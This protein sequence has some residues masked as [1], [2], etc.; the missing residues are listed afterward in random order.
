MKFRVTCAATPISYAQALDLLG[1]DASFR[2]FLTHLLASSEYGAF[3]WETPP[4]TRASASRPFEFV[5]VDDPYLNRSPDR[6]AFG[7]Y[8]ADAHE[9]VT[10]RAVPN[11]GGNATLIVPKEISHAEHYV[12][13]AAFL[14][15]APQS[16]VHAL[17]QCL[18]STGRSALAN[19]PTW[20]STAG[21]GVAWLHV[22]VEGQ[23][24]YYS[25]RPYAEDA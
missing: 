20:I 18:S 3:R 8:F 16:Q 24:K 21:G 6:A 2:E 9:L 11:L 10:V 15:G 14:R 23:P 17:W 7:S 4:I 13:I 25:Y 22:R 12:H 1:D 19:T 5:L